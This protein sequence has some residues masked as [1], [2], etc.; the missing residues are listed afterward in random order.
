M[1]GSRGRGKYLMRSVKMVSEEKEGGSRWE[2]RGSEGRMSET[3]ER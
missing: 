1:E 3:W 2:R